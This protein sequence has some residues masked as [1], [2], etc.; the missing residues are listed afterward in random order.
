M[1]WIKKIINK[2]KHAVLDIP[3][4]YY[5][6]ISSKSFQ[7]QKFFNEMISSLDE[8]LYAGAII[9]GIPKDKEKECEKEDEKAQKILRNAHDKDLSEVSLIT[10]YLQYAIADLYERDKYKDNWISRIQ[11]RKKEDFFPD[12][13]YIANL[14]EKSSMLDEEKYK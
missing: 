14:L 3:D 9:N 1:N 7:Y 5:K 10:A 4:E 12:H 13:N 2:I 11:H 8:K 6:E